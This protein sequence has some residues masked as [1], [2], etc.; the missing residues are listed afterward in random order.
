[1]TVLCR[2]RKNACIIFSTWIKLRNKVRYIN[3]LKSLCMVVEI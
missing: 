2:I 3:I 1:M